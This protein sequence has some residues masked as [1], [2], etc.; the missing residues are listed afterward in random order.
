[1][2][3]IAAED[4]ASGIFMNQPKMAES[5]PNFFF[6]ILFHIH[7]YEPKNIL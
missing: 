6:Q 2:K 3:G 5:S 4:F 1:M 7:G